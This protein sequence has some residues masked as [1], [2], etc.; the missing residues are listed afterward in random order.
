LIADPS[1]SYPNA[2]SKCHTKIGKAHNS[3]VHAQQSGFRT[4]LATRSGLDENSALITEVID[5][6]CSECHTSCGQCHI[7]RPDAVL[8]GL[9]LEHAIFKK[10]SDDENCTR[11]HGS[12][13]G[14]E[15][16]GSGFGNPADVHKMAGMG[17][18]D[19]HSGNEFH[20]SD[21]SYK[22]RYEVAESPLCTDCHT[23][24]EGLNDFHTKDHLERVA[25]QVCHSRPYKNCYQCHVGIDE[26]GILFPSEIDF[27]IGRNPI[28]SARHPQEF[29]VLRHPPI[30][31]DTF[32]DWGIELK[33]FTSLPTW[34]YATP[35][36]IRRYTPQTSRCE[37]CHEDTKYF[38]TTAYIQ[39]RIAEGI[40][41]GPELEA[42]APVI[43]DQ[44]SDYD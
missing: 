20:G 41:V 3:S 37:N 17:C 18:M 26:K 39:S 29:A 42:N 5:K 6:R 30:A 11:C 28:K 9:V 14:E 2:C 36:N 4:M 23:N 35:H 32:K 16:N 43:L 40:M 25:C 15:F 12:R 8:E 19:C 24:I 10:P 38:L 13:V 31:P 27:R 1:D 34:K 7:S 22:T 44:V 21:K 33:N